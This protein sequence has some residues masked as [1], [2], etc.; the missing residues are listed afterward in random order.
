MNPNRGCTDKVVINKDNIQ[1]WNYLSAI[2]FFSVG[3]ILLVKNPL[4]Y[5]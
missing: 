1:I 5:E 3:R 2:V 4:I